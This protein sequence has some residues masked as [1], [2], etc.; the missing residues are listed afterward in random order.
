MHIYTMLSCNDMASHRCE[1][2]CESLGFLSRKMRA[3]IR[4]PGRYIPSALDESLGGRPIV[5][6]GCTDYHSLHM[7]T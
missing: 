5:A 6:T 2:A 7:C 4:P 3:S 1:C